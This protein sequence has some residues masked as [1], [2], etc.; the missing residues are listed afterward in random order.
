[1]GLFGRRTKYRVTAP[2]GAVLPGR[3]LAL[4]LR[5][6][7]VRPGTTLGTLYAEVE[8]HGRK[9]TPV[10]QSEALAATSVAAS[11][12]VVRHE[13]VVDRALTEPEDA[14]EVKVF[15]PWTTPVV[16][17]GPHR[18]ISPVKIRVDHGY[19]ETLVET[20]GLAFH[21][22]LFAA[23]AE[24]GWTYKRCE[25]WDVGGRTRSAEQRLWFS[26]GEEF[27]TRGFKLAHVE[28]VG[29]AASETSGQLDVTVFGRKL[30]PGLFPLGRL[31]AVRLDAGD[32]D[33]CVTALRAGLAE[34]VGRSGVPAGVDL[35]GPVVEALLRVLLRG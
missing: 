9:E 6:T 18:L 27:E 16:R 33:A 24:V 23:A 5:A 34:V 31:D 8:V 28:V 35:E 15:L 7:K 11:V 2:E 29:R 32:P 13:I 26:P 12:P 4:T 22:A 17:V 25:V 14:V 20:E 21:D 3:E 1:M 30:G 19:G 10:V